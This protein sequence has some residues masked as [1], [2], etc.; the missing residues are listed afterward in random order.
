MFKLLTSS[1]V[2]L[3]IT[4]ITVLASADILRLYTE[5]SPPG[6][7]LNARGEVAGAT[8]ELIRLLLQ[9]FDQPATIELLPWARAMELAQSQPHTGLFETVRNP[10]REHYFKW[11]GPLK[12]HNINLYGRSDIFKNKTFTSGAKNQYL[13]CDYRESVHINTLKRLGFSEGRN[14]IL[15][16]NHGDC[17]NMLVRGRVQMILLNETSFTERQ[18]Q[19]QQTGNDLVLLQQLSSVWLYL[20]FS[21]DVADSYIF[22]WQQL[23]EQSY[24]DGT[25]RRLYQDIYTEQMITLLEGFAKSSAASR[26]KPAPA[27]ND[28]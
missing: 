5:H 9:R 21:L 22:R 16:V 10:E 18:L 4:P 20:A 24:L 28:N 8:T 11:V 12:M 17:F 27:T 14:L 25:M 2:M 13:A 6:E 15:T 7:Y 19:M 3:F 26:Q 23:L 1:M